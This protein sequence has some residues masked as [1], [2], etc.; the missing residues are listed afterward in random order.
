MRK[1]WLALLLALALMAPV[2]GLAV[3][4]AVEG[5][6]I[7]DEPIT[8]KIA[9]MKPPV[10]PDFS[11]VIILKNFEEKS[12]IHVEWESIPNEMVT[13]RRNLMFASLDLPDIMMK[14]SV[15]ALDQAAYSAQGILLPLNALIEQYA[16]NVQYWFEQF[17]EVKVGL[18]L[19]DG[20]IYSLGYI[21][22]TPAITAGGRYFFNSEVLAHAGLDK[23]PTT[24]DGL[25]EYFRA[26]KGWD[27]NGNGQDDEIPV[28]SSSYDYIED[29]LKG[30]WGLGT[31]GRNHAYV[32]IDKEGKP[33]FIYTTDEYKE[34][35]QYI[36]TLYTEKLLDQDIFTMEHAQL[37]TKA[38]EGRALT[39]VFVN[40]NV[41]TNTRY[42]ELAVGMTEPFKGPYGDQIANNFSAALGSAGGALV[43]TMKNQYPEASM[44][45]ADYWY[46]DDGM[47]EYFMGVEGETYYVDE[48]GDYQFTDYVI[49]NPDG[50]NYEQVLGQYCPW[51]GGGNPSVAGAKYFKGGE[52]APV[53]RAAA[54]ALEPFKP[55]VIWPAFRYGDEDNE[56]MK[57]L[58]NDI[59]TYRNEMRAAFVTGT[60]SFDEWDAYVAGYNA[61]GLDQYMEIYT[62]AIEALDAQ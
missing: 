8:L 22:A 5:F 24:T 11:E 15:S 27:Y 12:G 54:E 53:P 49:K 52:M 44:R 30:S 50:I 25:L 16:P 38:Q 10:C 59:Q 4:V 3:N 6:P 7:V 26:I 46:S 55:E 36:N 62:R 58:Q 43:L 37:I 23:A 45:W 42:Q 28:S 21:Y 61:L 33:R 47:R 20:E 35:L 31:R 14:M 41:V 60:K 39:Y 1:T 57:V 32:D 13:E 2:G 19:P 29:I 17:P 9:T 48:N 56:T 40:D 34:I 18:T 51:L